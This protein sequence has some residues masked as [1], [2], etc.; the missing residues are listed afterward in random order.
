MQDVCRKLTRE[1][2]NALPIRTYRGRI[3]LVRREEEV[4][5]AVARLAQ[6]RVLGFD[7]EARPSFKRGEKHPAALLQLAGADW[8]CIFRLL[9]IGLPAVLRDLLA[10][11]GVRKVGVSLKDDIKEL[12]GLSDFA[13]GGFVDLGEAARKAGLMHHGL[14]GLAALLFGFRISKSSQRSNWANEQL[15]DKQIGY[16]ATDAWLSRELYFELLRHAVALPVMEASAAG[17]QREGA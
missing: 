9:D 3:Q 12:R 5:D 13:P 6:D 14:K 4:A 7:V 2:I 15:T 10:D 11:A 1:E 16:A 8:V 17:G